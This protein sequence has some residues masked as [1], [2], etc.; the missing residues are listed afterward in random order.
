MSSR[1]KI[2]GALRTAN[3]ISAPCVA[4]AKPCERIFYCSNFW[5]NLSLPETL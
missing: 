2:L 3:A 1:R 4:S 5:T